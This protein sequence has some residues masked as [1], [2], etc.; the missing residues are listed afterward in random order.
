VS[1]EQGQGRTI[2][3]EKLDLRETFIDEL[4][5]LAAAESRLVVLDADVSRT[6]RSRRFRDAYPDRFFDMGIAEQDMTGVAAGLANVGLIPV[7]V[8][9]AVFATMRAAEPL[10]TSICYPELNAKVIGGYAALSNSKDGATHHSIEDIAITRAFPNLVVLTPSDGVMA[11]KV[12]RAAVAHDG[13]V[14]IRLE[15]ESSPRIYEPDVEFVIGRG[16]QLRR[17]EDVTIVSCGLAVVRALE[18]ARRLSLDGIEADVLD[19]ASLKPLDVELLCS[20]VARTGALV[21]LEDHNVHGGLGS[22]AARAVL[23]AG[24]APAFRSIGIADTFTE[25]AAKA[26][27]LR[28]K[29]GVSAD[30]VVEAVRSLRM[31]PAPAAAGVST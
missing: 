2:D 5:E 27:E 13:P 31:T 15:Y 6:S 23:E 7:T 22:A 11:R 19:M 24:L 1:A 9:F 18:A 12:L 14:Y 20:S 25:S 30:A 3:A 10:R 16:H 29:Y 21:V 26:D 17:G 4:I 8:T 28:A